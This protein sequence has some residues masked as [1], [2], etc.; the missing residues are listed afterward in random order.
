MDDLPL[1]QEI[2]DGIEVRD[3]SGV[4]ESPDVDRAQARG[5]GQEPRQ[6]GHRPSNSWIRSV[7]TTRAPPSSRRIAG[8][9][10][11]ATATTH[12]GGGGRS[13]PPGDDPGIRLAAQR[14]LVHAFEREAE[15]PI[16]ASIP[17]SIAGR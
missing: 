2:D 10:R 14:S 15:L 4:V 3:Q 7:S 6:L 13:L 11:V 12:H 9:S 8:T 5:L 16:I 1:P 17:N